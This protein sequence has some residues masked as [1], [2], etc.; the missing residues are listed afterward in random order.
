MLYGK[1]RGIHLFIA[2]ICLFSLLNAGV[3]E[4]DPTSLAK[5]FSKYQFDV[6]TTEP[7]ERISGFFQ[8]LNVNVGNIYTISSYTARAMQLRKTDLLIIIDRKK[9]GPDFLLLERLVGITSN[10]VGPNSVMVTAFRRPGGSEATRIMFTAPD[11][12]SLY[13][14]LDTMPALPAYNER[15]EDSGFSVIRDYNIV[16]LNFFM[17]VDKQI[18]EDWI[19]NISKPGG[20]IYNC[21]YEAID[22]YKPDPSGE[23]NP[24]F[25]I[26]TAIK[27]KE[28]VMQA[29]P[30]AFSQWLSSNGKYSQQA[31]MSGAT[32]AAKSSNKTYAFAA[33][34]VRHLENLLSKY[35][36]IS[37]VPEKLE[38][39]DL[40][41]LSHLKRL[42]IV[43]YRKNP[44]DVVLAGALSALNDKL[45]AALT[46]IKPGISFIPLQNPDTVVRW[47]EGK[48]TK[49]MDNIDGIVTLQITDYYGVSTPAMTSFSITKPT[50][51]TIPKKTVPG[52]PAKLKQ[53]KLKQK[54]YNK[55]L[56]L[57]ESE[58]RSYQ[59]RLRDAAAQWM[60]QEPISGACSITGKFSV[61]GRVDQFE[62]QILELEFHAS[63][64]S[65]IVKT[66]T[67]NL[68][69]TYASADLAGRLL[70][71]CVFPADVDVSK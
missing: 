41:D 1:L 62:K 31:A 19:A 3:S 6:I 7:T 8:S 29:L 9:V 4:A 35:E 47:E 55:S 21:S 52:Y 68:A 59:R 18:A 44:T 23:T 71:K 20:N 30:K 33:P 39:A 58:K 11:E 28:S 37:A 16:T 51:P 24:V 25:I 17:N 42:G 36:E 10:E 65:N 56:A 14:E 61:Y 45:A 53:Y 32:A 13:H 50:A 49:S 22:A 40:I 70:S 5:L 26:N 38:T 43:V 66:P 46:N 60:S 54:A 15:F 34:G 2:A 69:A 57:W 67:I 64:D 63:I 12:K 48:K 27:V